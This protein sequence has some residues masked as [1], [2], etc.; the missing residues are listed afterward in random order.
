MLAV[1]VHEVLSTYGT[2]YAAPLRG[3]VFRGV[4][5]GGAPLLGVYE[6][7]GVRYAGEMS[8]GW[9][10]GYGLYMCAGTAY[11]GEFVAG[12]R[13]GLGCLTTSSGSQ[14]GLFKHNVYH[15]QAH[16]ADLAEID[17]LADDVSYIARELADMCPRVPGSP[18]SVAELSD[19]DE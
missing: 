4:W 15:H 9:P 3:G 10:D 2:P 11:K 5:R 14:R 18:W 7:D 19:D 17:A 13:E 16:R 6:S 1:H 8:R 12:A